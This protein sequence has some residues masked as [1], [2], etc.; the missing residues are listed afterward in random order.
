M[1]ERQKKTRASSSSSKPFVHSVPH[2]DPATYVDAWQMAE[3]NKR[4]HPPTHPSNASIPLGRTPSHRASANSVTGQQAN[5]D[6]DCAWSHEIDSNNGCDRTLFYN[7]I[8]FST[9]IPHKSYT[10]TTS[11]TV[12]GCVGSHFGCCIRNPNGM[13]NEGETLPSLAIRSHNP[14]FASRFSSRFANNSSS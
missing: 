1:G 10:R 8:V 11:T 6:T 9:S 3:S 2:R 13:P 12:K 4:T 7:R 5:Y 14:P